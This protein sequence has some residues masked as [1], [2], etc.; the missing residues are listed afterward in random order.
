[1]RPVARQHAQPNVAM[2]RNSRRAKVM[3]VP[4][5]PEFRRASRTTVFGKYRG[6]ALRKLI[7]HRKSSNEYAIHCYELLVDLLFQQ[8]AC[9]L[10][11]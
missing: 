6:A 9:I 10:V 7:V 11:L 4:P 2:R 3:K 8:I 1:V 5:E